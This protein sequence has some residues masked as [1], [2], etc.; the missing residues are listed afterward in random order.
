MRT[1][2]ELFIAPDSRS[3]SSYGCVVN[4]SITIYQLYQQSAME[5]QQAS[6]GRSS[7]DSDKYIKYIVMCTAVFSKRVI[8]KHQ[9]SVHSSKGEQELEDGLLLCMA[10]SVDAQGHVQ[11]QTRLFNT[12]DRVANLRK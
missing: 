1:T 9:T 4:I 8:H 11:P 2:S 3:D 5:L 12:V 7:K 10:Y 6:W